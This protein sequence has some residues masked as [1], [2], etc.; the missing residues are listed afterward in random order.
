[1]VG[2]RD[3][4]I[5]AYDSDP[6]ELSSERLAIELA[7]RGY[8]ISVLKGGINDWMTAKLPV[9]SKPWPQPASAAGAKG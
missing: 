7:R 4:D 6:D 2:P 3:R 9:E 8:R 5:V 1:M